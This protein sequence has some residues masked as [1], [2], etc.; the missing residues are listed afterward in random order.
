MTDNR[1]AIRSNWEDPHERIRYMLRRLEKRETTP[2]VSWSEDDHAD[3]RMVAGIALAALDLRDALAFLYSEEIVNDTSPA[4][5]GD[6]FSVLDAALHDEPLPD[7]YDDRHWW[8]EVYKAAIA[9][10]VMAGIRPLR[11]AEG[12]N[13]T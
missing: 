10:D 7:V 13:D 11:R 6:L 1:S 4:K 2:G 5:W 9:L 8:R 12:G 3:V